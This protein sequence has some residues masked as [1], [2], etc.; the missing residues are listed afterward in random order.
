MSSLGTRDHKYPIFGFVL[1][2]VRESLGMAVWATMAPPLPVA[3]DSG[4]GMRSTPAG[5]AG[6]MPTESGI[7]RR[8]DSLGNWRIDVRSPDQRALVEADSTVPL[9]QGRAVM[10]VSGGAVSA[11]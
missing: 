9:A 8:E 5:R 4:K 3:K 2:W 7:T 6:E 11:S 1:C 10:I